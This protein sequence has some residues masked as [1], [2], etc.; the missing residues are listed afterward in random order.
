MKNFFNIYRASGSTKRRQRKEIRG[1]APTLHYLADSTRLPILITA[2]HIL[3][4]SLSTCLIDYNFNSLIFVGEL[5]NW[6]QPI[7]F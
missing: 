6:R 1:T 7:R 3:I 4:A 2:R 5:K